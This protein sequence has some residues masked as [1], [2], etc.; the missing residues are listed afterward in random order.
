ML[1]HQNCK[2]S[3]EIDAK[4]VGG[5]FVFAI[6]N[7][8]VDFD[9]YDS[10]IKSYIDERFLYRVNPGFHRESYLNVRN[11]HVKLA[12]GFLQIGSTQDLQ[13]Y[14]VDTSENDFIFSNSN[15]YV[16]VYLNM[17]AREDTYE[18]TVFS[19]F[20]LT[21]LVGGVFEILEL[22]GGLFVSFFAH[23]LFM[24]SM[25][26]DL[27]QVEKIDS[28]HGFS[29]VI[30]KTKELKVVKKRTKC[31]YRVYEETKAPE[32]ADKNIDYSNA[33]LNSSSIN[34]IIEMQ[35]NRNFNRNPITSRKSSRPNLTLK[36]KKLDFMVKLREVLYNRRKFA[37]S[38][39]DY[40][41]EVLCCCK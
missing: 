29:K 25:L 18:R 28:N 20:D 10:I 39:S 11:N 7:S 24:F 27:Y 38:S 23:K 19:F 41:Y 1:G 17:E 37:Y 36:D 12:D 15:S 35:N 22:A 9:D 26:N 3:D 14:N 13:F 34:E 4:L 32:I 16:S 21:G 2:S 30:P 8:Y 33:Q 40:L 31:D 5:R 6:I